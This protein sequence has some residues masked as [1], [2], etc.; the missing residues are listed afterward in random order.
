MPRRR[1]NRWKSFTR[2]V[3]HVMLQM[4]GTQSFN[5][6]FQ[7][8]NT[9]GVN[10]ARWDGQMIGGT[11]ASNN[12]E[13][14]Q[15]FRRAYGTTLT[16]TTVDDYKLFIKSLCLDIQISNIGDKNVI[17]EMH[18]LVMRKNYNVGSRI[19]VCYTD[20]LAE[21]PPQTGFTQAAPTDVTS[22][23][24]QNSLFCQ[25]WRILKKTQIVISPGETTTLQLRIP[26]NRMLQGKLIE[27][28]PMGIPGFT[29]ALFWQAKGSPEYNAPS[30]QHSNFEI[31]WQCQTFVNYQIPPSS[32]RTAT[33]IP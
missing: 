5:A 30:V 7:G 23:L 17:L 27:T 21:V 24:F 28:N 6:L 4:G 12:D 29:R 15:A 11:T 31:V 32:S 20:T 10:T 1:R 3:Q 33:S 18:T 22:T 9:E 16:T 14:F 25:Y 19:D 13:L 8:R 2:K 26:Y